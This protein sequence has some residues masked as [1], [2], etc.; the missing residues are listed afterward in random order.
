MKAIIFIL[1]LLFITT[2][3]AQQKFD[4]DGKTKA[5]QELLKADKVTESFTIWSEV[6]TNCPKQSEELYTDGIR[7][8]KYKV[9]TAPADGKEKPVRDL[10]KLYDQYNKNFPT[11]IPD[12]EV[13]KAMALVNNKIDAKDEIFGLLESG[14][15]KASKNVRDVKAIH[16][17]FTMYCERYKAGDKKITATAVLEKYASLSA[18]LTQL[19]ESTSNNGDFKS[20]QH[21]IDSLVKDIATCDNLTELYT[22][23]FEAN[24]DNA[25]W[26]QTALVSLSGKCSTRPI[27][28]TLA[29]R[30]YTLEKT[31]MSANF[32][33]MAYV[34][35]RKF[36]EA[37]KFYDEAAGL[38]T[39]P[40]EKGKIYYTVATGLLAND[41]P[42]SK[43][44]LNRA[45][46]ANPQMGRAYLFLA[47]LYANRSADCALGETE[48]K[49][50][51]NLA[52]Q[53]LQ[54]AAVAEPELKATVDNMKSDFVTKA[55]TPSEISKAK[56]NGKSVTIGCWINETVSF[57][58][59]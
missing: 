44:Y 9:E 14:F 46:T 29:E 36:T 43:E 59:N 35:E 41:L 25:N 18:L 20:A 11:G 45:V 4:C 7:I 56:L 28:L 58:A 40:V 47:Q 17:Y 26:I 22:K 27:F 32:V 5:Y 33:A 53:T 55:L 37:M 42:K 39:N 50:V 38:Q 21:A 34:K 8:L 52:I 19:K 23:N 49:A 15:T 10:M 1:G 51:Y 24:K 16:T 48:K 31:A 30:L 57:P 54:K 3:N 6:R 12:F 13:R 2:G